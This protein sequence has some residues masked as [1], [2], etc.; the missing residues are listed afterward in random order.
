[1]DRVQAV[2][3]SKTCCKPKARLEYDNAHQTIIYEAR[4]T[5]IKREFKC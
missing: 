5:W 3:A 2:P 1:L 4:Y